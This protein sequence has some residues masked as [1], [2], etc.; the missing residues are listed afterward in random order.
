M[1]STPNGSSASCARRAPSPPSI[2]QHRDHP[3]RRGGGG[4]PFPHHG[5]GR[6]PRS[7]ES[8]RRGQL[9]VD[10]FFDIAIRAGRRARRR[11]R[12]GITHRDLKPANIMVTATGG[13][14]CSTSV[15]PRSPRWRGPGSETRTLRDR[16]DDAE[17][18]VMGT[19]RTCRPSRPGAAARPPHGHLLARHR[20]VRDGDGRRPF[21]GESS[22]DLVASILRDTPPSV[23]EL[24]ADC[25]R[26]RARASGAASRR[27]SRSDS[28]PRRSC[29]TDC[30]A[31]RRGRRPSG[32]RRPP[33]RALRRP[34]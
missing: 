32:R 34:R 16:D 14:R 10:R 6:R 8:F 15:S 7:T 5:T 28:R 31:C 12:E 30:A 24:R 26:S 25:R 22:A 9:P 3:L 33:F 2:T 19:G 13:S 17:G 20:A 29:A 23:V 11:A 21:D 18:V 1:A 4:R 27:A